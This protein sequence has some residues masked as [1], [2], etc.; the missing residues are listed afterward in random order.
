LGNGVIHD[1]KKNR[2]GFDPQLIEELGQSDL[3]NLFHGPDILSQE[4][5]KA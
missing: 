1:E 5:S 2:I 3:C 4:S